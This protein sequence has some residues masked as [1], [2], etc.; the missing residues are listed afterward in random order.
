[1]LLPLLLDWLGRRGMLVV[2]EGRIIKSD[3]HSIASAAPSRLFPQLL[4]LL[5]LL[6]LG[7]PLW[8]RLLLLKLAP[9]VVARPLAV[10][11]LALRPPVAGMRQLGHIRR[12]ETAWQG[13]AGLAALGPAAVAALILCCSCNRLRGRQHAALHQGGRVLLQQAQGK[14]CAAV[15]VVDRWLPPKLRL[16]L[17]PCFLLA[18]AAQQPARQGGSG[19]VEGGPRPAVGGSV[20]GVCGGASMGGVAESAARSRRPALLQKAHVRSRAQ[21]RQQHPAPLKAAYVR[22]RASSGCG[23]CSAA[24]SRHRDASGMRAQ[25]ALKASCG[26]ERARG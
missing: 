7:C 9:D 26:D 19:A 11:H 23:A 6:G 14:G 20:G 18:L 1:M 4:S 24:R 12:L 13:R 22:S 15:I 5:L 3:C 21:L 2:G 17:R 8:S 25:L 16:R 10:V